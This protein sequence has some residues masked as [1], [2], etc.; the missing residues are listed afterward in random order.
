MMASE[1]S[2]VTHPRGANGRG[3]A[4]TGAVP[5]ERANQAANYLL[6][7]MARGTVDTRDVKFVLP[8]TGGSMTGEVTLNYVSDPSVVCA[9]F[10]TTR[11]DLVR[12]RGS[13]EERMEQLREMDDDAGVKRKAK[14]F[15]R[16][17]RRLDAAVQ[18]ASKLNDP[19][20]RIYSLQ[21]RTAMSFGGGP[22]GE[23]RPLKPAGLVMLKGTSKQ[24]GEDEVYRR[25]MEA[26]LLMGDFTTHDPDTLHPRFLE[27][28]HERTRSLPERETRAMDWAVK[29]MR[30]LWS[31]RGVVAEARGIESAEPGPL[32]LMM[33]P[34][35]AGEFQHA[36][37]TNRKDPQVVE[38]LSKAVKRFYR[39]GSVVAMRG[40]RPAWVDFTQ[41][42]TASFG[43]KE[44]KAAK[45]VDGRRV[46][47]VPR[48]IFCPSPVNYATGAFLHAD[49]SH[50]LQAKDPSHGPGFG[51]GRGRAWKLLDKVSAHL[52]PDGSANLDCDAIM[53]DIA[54]WDA[55][56][57]EVLIG[58]AFDLLESFVDKSKLDAVGRAT[59]SLMVDTVRRQLMVKLV[60]HPSG[61]FIELFGCMPSGSF[62]TSALNTIGN[63]LLALS[64]LAMAIMESG[65]D[66]ND[67]DI[68]QV[69]SAVETDLVSYG[70]NQL[71][72]SSLFTRFGTAYSIRRHERH[73][74]AFGMRLKV[75]ETDVSSRL[76]D[77]R[78]CSRGV[79]QTPVGLAIT[80]SHTS[81]YNKLGGTAETDPVIL[82]MYIRALMV[83]LLGTDPVLYSG[84]SELERMVD[85]PPDAKVSETRLKAMVEPFAR[86]L[87]GSGDDL[88]IGKFIELL[89]RPTAPAR[90]VLLSLRVPV[91]DVRSVRGFGLSLSVSSD[92]DKVG[93]DE[94]GMWLNSLDPSGFWKY[95][96]QTD[97]MG[98][99]YNN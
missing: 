89:R 48:F 79:L 57:P 56:M 40:R 53:S 22:P 29:V 15:V 70:D 59:R 61:Y 97:Q 81:I 67:V 52:S 20:F 72:F 71:I 91:D 66:L 83:D 1:T 35:T 16:D 5:V 33:N 90:A 24:I 14:E 27:Y 10:R 39:A 51:P 38:L 4:H 21:R 86:K 76:C 77:V 75:D 92:R 34:G 93:L 31:K 94:V 26:A 69:A 19:S 18:A 23:E 2:F 74:A 85:I 28:V 54:K 45:L 96:K 88:S 80:R 37:F 84:L 25:E 43:K 65:Q 30:A 12:I 36:G 55:N 46:A 17:S 49:I 44:R 78:F 95:L 41:Q 64:L 58:Y 8:G 98:V 9:P 68:D 60:E 62:Y 42:P 47:P 7:R 99:V 63:D 87:F 50:Q 3:V 82:K 11:A 13:Q 6:R 73:L 32:S